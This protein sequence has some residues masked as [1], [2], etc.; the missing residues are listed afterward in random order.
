MREV[1]KLVWGFVRSNKNLDNVRESLVHRKIPYSEATNFILKV[2]DLHGNR[3]EFEF[4]PLKM[5]F[6]SKER[7]KAFWNIRNDVEY[8]KKMGWKPLLP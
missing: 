5:P 8:R 3:D 2:M 1:W 6:K 4:D 7:E